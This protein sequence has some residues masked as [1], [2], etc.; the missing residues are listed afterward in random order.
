M[1]LKYW[2]W[3]F[4]IF[5]SK[6]VFQ[7][8]KKV[9]FD[10]ITM[11]TCFKDW[12]GKST[13]FD[14]LHGSPN[15]FVQLAF[16]F[17]RNLVSAKFGQSDVVDRTSQFFRKW[18]VGCVRLYSNDIQPNMRTWRSKLTDFVHNGLKRLI[19]HQLYV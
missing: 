13:R 15:H 3:Y 2:N 7:N 1:F 8:L 18:V 11:F 6:Y 19:F 12:T 14:R 5:K 16:E 17:G 9:I 4:I 10:K